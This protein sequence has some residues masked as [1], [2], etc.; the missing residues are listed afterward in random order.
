MVLQPTWV[1]W[2]LVVTSWWR[3]CH[4]KVTTSRTPFFSARAHHEE[5]YTS[6]HIEE[7]E[8]VAR[9]T[10]LGK[11]EI[12]RDIPNVGEEALKD[13]DEPVSLESAPRFTQ[14]ISSSVR[15]RRRVRP[16]SRRKKSSCVPSSVRRLATFVTRRSAYHQG[17]P[18]QLSTRKSS[19]V[20]A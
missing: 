1:S 2:P 15:L 4:G 3:S 10:K 20:R 14:V 6:V 19:P 8:C 13:L 17:L 12:T 16:S 11:E 5:D 9:D 18:E 7:F